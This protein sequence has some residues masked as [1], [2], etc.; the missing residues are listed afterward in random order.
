MLLYRLHC[1]ETCAARCTEGD[2]SA[3]R[4]SQSVQV[5]WLVSY[6]L[7]FIHLSKYDIRGVRAQTARWCIEG[8]STLNWSDMPSELLAICVTLIRAGNNKKSTTFSKI[9]T[10]RQS[11]PYSIRELYYNTK[12]LIV[13]TTI[14]KSL[15]FSKSLPLGRGSDFIEVAN[16]IG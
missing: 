1:S 5:D 11:I 2:F 6:P 12:S 4:R 7:V 13:F 10:F 15:P 14:I 8:H 9:A 16:A 3:I